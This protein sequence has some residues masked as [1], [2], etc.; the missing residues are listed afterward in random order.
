MKPEPIDIVRKIKDVSISSILYNN[1]DFVFGSQHS[2]TY[3]NVFKNLNLKRLVNAI[4]TLTF[5]DYIQ[6]DYDIDKSKKKLSFLLKDNNDMLFNDILYIINSLILNRKITFDRIKG[7]YINPLNSNPY[8]SI[9]KKIEVILN[10]FFIQTYKDHIGHMMFNADKF[11]YIILYNL[12]D[13]RIDNINMKCVFRDL[14][15]RPFFM[16]NY[17]LQMNDE[18]DRNENYITIPVLTFPFSK[19]VIT[20][21]LSFDNKRYKPDDKDGEII[22][23]RKSYKNK[24]YN[25]IIN[26]IIHESVNL[27]LQSNPNYGTKVL[28][29]YYL[30]RDSFY[31]GN[32]LYNKICS[33]HK[34]EKSSRHLMITNNDKIWLDDIIT[35]LDYDNDKLK[36]LKATSNK[37]MKDIRLDTPSWIDKLF[38]IENMNGIVDMDKVLQTLNTITNKNYS[39][40]ALSFIF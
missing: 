35:N 10:N 29:N 5:N 23:T 4:T 39:V 1:L 15:R 13:N 32:V 17:V 24:N 40:T 30:D 21:F 27:Y 22:V 9:M 8:S 14:D 11:K 38:A 34:D 7:K 19:E 12:L 28:T 37:Y 26:S 6:D 25:E 31:L 2:T 36:L 3:I 33:F 18:D 20:I 16:V